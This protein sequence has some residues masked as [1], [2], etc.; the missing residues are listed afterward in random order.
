VSDARRLLVSV[1]LL[2]AVGGC[3]GL[4]GQRRSD[5]YEARKRLAR[6]LIGQQDWSAAFFYA[7]QLH[8]EAPDDAEVLVL[9]GTIYRE[10]GLPAEAEADLKEALKRQDGLPEAHA[11]LGI[12]YDMSSR[13]E[14]AEAH[15]RKAVMLAQDNPVYLN[16]L[17]FSLFLRRKNREAIEIYQRAAR[18]S[19]VTPRI[20]TN[21]GFAY[22]AM[23]DLPRAAREFQMG[24]APAEAKNNLGFAYEQRG[25]L[26]NAYALY[27]EA[28]RLD[29]RCG[30]A[31]ANLVYVARKLGKDIPEDVSKVP[32]EAVGRSGNK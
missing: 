28:L 20:R 16:N 18:M 14:S 26:A 32:A 15:H 29:P 21:L 9:R 8:R 27:I 5:T 1:L 25:D 12:M 3:G 17:G 7:D 10:R 6:E 30:H 19:P 23:G 13:G 24:A 4:M 22:A 2:S 31:R 11:A